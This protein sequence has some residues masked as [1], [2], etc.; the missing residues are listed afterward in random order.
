MDGYSCL[1]VWICLYQ[2]RILLNSTPTH[3]LSIT[4]GTRIFDL[5]PKPLQMLMF[6][7]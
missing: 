3:L 1:F 5:L 7:S 6:L 2:L 4:L